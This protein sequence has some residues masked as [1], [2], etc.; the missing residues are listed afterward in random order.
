MTNETCSCSYAECINITIALTTPDLAF[1]ILHTTATKVFRD[2]V[3]KYTT[4]K[5]KVIVNPVDE[6]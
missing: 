1:Q 3:T 5:N 2:I 4:L 6:K